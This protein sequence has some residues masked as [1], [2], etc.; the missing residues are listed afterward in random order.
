MLEP[1][2]LTYIYWI[3]GKGIKVKTPLVL[4][5]SWAIQ[6]VTSYSVLDNLCITFSFGVLQIDWASTVWNTSDYNF[7]FS[8]CLYLILYL[9]GMLQWQITRVLW[10]R[11]TVSCVYVHSYKVS[12]PSLQ[13][14]IW[15]N[16]NI[17]STEVSKVF[18]NTFTYFCILYIYL[19]MYSNVSR[20]THKLTFPIR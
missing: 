1:A 8:Q 12:M 4:E 2:N 18:F 16:L 11:Q 14:F 17:L 15:K 3:L 13:S 19:S 20:E 5:W 7:C 9:S 6:V 10:D